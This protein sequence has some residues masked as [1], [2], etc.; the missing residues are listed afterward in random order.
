MVAGP[1]GLEP[2]RTVLE[3]VML[4]I[5]SW[6]YGAGDRNRTC[7]NYSPLAWKASALPTELHPHLNI[8]L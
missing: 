3:T 8:Y 7:V 2:S 4:P 6:P 5:T 1:E